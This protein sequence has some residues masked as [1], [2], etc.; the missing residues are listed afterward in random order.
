MKDEDY[1]CN[2]PE[3]IHDWV[4]GTDLSDEST[5]VMICEVCVAIAAL[6]GEWE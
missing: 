4:L 5:A 1:P 6:M 2:T 3:G